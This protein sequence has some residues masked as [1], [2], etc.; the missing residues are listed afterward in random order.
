MSEFKTVTLEID[1]QVATICLNRPDNLNSFNREMRLELLT[2]I[3]RVAHDSEIRVLVLG[4]V[5]RAFSAGADLGGVALPGQTVEEQLQEE[6][7]PILHHIGDMEQ[8][9]IAAIPGVMAGIGAAFAMHSDL[10][11]MADNGRMVMAFSNVGL[12]PDGGASWN[13]L[14]YLGY[15][16]AYALIAEGGQLGAE[17]CLAA[18]IVNRLVPADE[19]LATAQAWG[20]SLAA[21]PPIAL[22]SA[23]R[24][25]RNAAHQSYQE[26]FAAEAKAQLA[27]L[28]SEDSQE[29]IAAFHEK[30]KPVFKGR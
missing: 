3:R 23:K 26:V 8:T 21:R 11:V 17:D 1:H 4:G 28:A 7:G 18:G 2:A 30:R 19:V 27:C 10:A 6:Y 5:G 14:R 24:L 29:A 25:L 12:V 20:K 9:V 16:R 22:R 15:Q 13:L